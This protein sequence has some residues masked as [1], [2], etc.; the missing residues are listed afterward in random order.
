MM[1]VQYVEGDENCL[2]L[3]VYSTTLN[4]DSKIPVM[5]YIHGGAFM[6]G[7]GDVESGYG[8]EFLLQHDVVLVTLNYRLEILG[9]LCLDTPDVPGNAGM[10]DQ[11][12]ALRWVRDNIQQFGGD[13]NNVTLFGE[14]AGGA[15]VVYHMQSLMSRGLFHKGICQSGA[16][17]TDWTQGKE[18]L[19]RAFRVAKYLG[20]DTNDKEELYDFLKN[21][22]VKKFSKITVKTMTADEKIRGLPI[23]FAPVVEKRFDNVEPFLTEEL[24]ETLLQSNIMKIPMI[25]GYNNLEGLLMLPYQLKRVEF[26]NK[27]PHSFVPREIVS[28]ITEEKTIE[29]GQRLKKFYFGENEIST[30]TIASLLDLLSDLHFVFNTHRFAH[31]YS[32]IHEQLYM[33]R[34]C[35]DTDLNM[36]KILSGFSHLKGACH[37]DDLFYIFHNALN[38]DAYQ[39]QKMLQDIVFRLTKLW[40]DFA[41]T[42]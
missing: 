38:K 1:T 5:V 24:I 9:F 10:K 41:K 26:L 30:H 2:F 32:S 3:N 35:L 14:S 6:S 12:A 17:L 7:S 29:F 37:A 40:T 8:P 21:I 16:P 34:L 42:G 4:L 23:H 20:K 25:L 39:E 15:S 18:G 19:R 22:P 13:P 28:V 31:F 11:V 27:N 36:V 33:F